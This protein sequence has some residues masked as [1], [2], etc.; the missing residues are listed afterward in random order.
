MSVAGAVALVLWLGLTAGGAA[1]WWRIERPGSTVLSRRSGQLAVLVAHLVVTTAVAVL[2]AVGGALDVPWNWLGV[3][4]AAI[5][6]VVNGGVVTLAVLALADSTSSAQT[7][8]SHAGVLR[9]GAWVGALERLGLVGTVLAGTPEGIVAILAV[10]SLARYPE[11]KV[12]QDSGASERFIIGTFT[13]LGWAAV[14]AGI[15]TLLR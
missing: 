7:G 8:P 9:G 4:V 11:L 15:A 12:G 1:I 13:S 14:C 3:G 6:A 10:K 5:S 2:A